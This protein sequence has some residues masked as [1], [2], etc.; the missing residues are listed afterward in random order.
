MNETTLEA[1]LVDG[2]GGLRLASPRPG[3]VRLAVSPGDVLRAG[4]PFAWHESLG[5]TR[6]LLVP[7]GA[8]GVVQGRP[9]LRQ[10]LGWG[11][12]IVALA[13]VDGDDAASAG[14]DA[15]SEA[16][17]WTLE[18]PMD[19]QLYQRANPETPPFV[20]VGDVVQP[21]QT[22]GLVEVMKF[23]YPLTFDGSAGPMV[24]AGWL[25]PDATPVESGARI[26]RFRP[27]GGE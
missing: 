10:A 9:P 4:Q 3:H 19:G 25:V 6:V 14:S 27:V 17:G 20:A 12:T 18:A 21:G 7:A 16:D 5:R 26:A 22:I 23:F 1:L 13:P 11:E 24:F 8:Q 2:E 15:A